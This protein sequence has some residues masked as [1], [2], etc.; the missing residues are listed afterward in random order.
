MVDRRLLPL[1][2]LPS[3]GE[4]VRLVC[5]RRLQKRYEIE[6][7]YRALF[8]EPSL[9]RYRIAMAYL[10]HRW[11]IELLE[12]ALTRGAHVELLLPERS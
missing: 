4:R 8:S 3:D 7:T 9:T 6:P 5:N 2:T 11:G 10:G 12:C 1:V